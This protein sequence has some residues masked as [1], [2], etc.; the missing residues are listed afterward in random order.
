[1][2]LFAT[3]ALIALFSSVV[4]TILGYPIGNWLAGTGRRTRQLVSSFLLVPFLLPPFLIGITLL[5]LQP[6]TF[7]S[8]TGILWIIGAHVLM[9]AGFMAR[10]VSANQIPADQ[11]EAASL[12]GASRVRKRFAIE[13]PQQLAGML[14]A[15]LLVALYSATSYGLVLTLGAG[16]V[17]TLET[18]IATA[19]LRDLDLNFALTL[20]LLQTA[21]TLCFFYL[22]RSI[23][24]EPAPLFGEQETASNGSKLGGLLAALLLA[25]IVI[26]FAG[27]FVRAITYGP[28]LVENFA[29]LAGRGGR[30]ILNI[31][32]AEAALNSLRNLIVAALI[33]LPIAWFAAG[34]KRTSYLVLLPIGISPVVFGLVFLVLSGYLPSALSG[35]WLLVP[36]VQSLFLIPLSYQVLRPAR[37]S[38]SMEIID[39]A[40]LDGAFGWRMFSE[41]EGPLIRKP[42]SVAAAF[43][44][45]GSLGEFGAASFLAYGS[46]ATLP[47]VMFRLISRPGAENLGMAMAAASLFIAVAL[48]VVWVIS[49]EGRTQ[50]QER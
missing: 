27:V 12:D 34:R 46:Q 9:N 28:G 42:L 48:V 33:A 44:A 14:S 40:Q 8:I 11:L 41:V 15:G 49:L 25:A 31:S 7:N 26:V 22:A 2:E 10:V 21:L 39:A 20:A 3:T 32:V 16:K 19:A 30:E 5:P 29:N 47:L 24:A 43:V 50:R 23:G 18:E 35:T 37:Q 1:M 38:V 13:L 36:V 17:D 6:N 4:A 45:L